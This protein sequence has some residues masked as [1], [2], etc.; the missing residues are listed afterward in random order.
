MRRSASDGES[1]LTITTSV[2]GSIREF[3][4]WVGNREGVGE[5]TG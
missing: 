2:T 1:M 5:F 3:V 4:E